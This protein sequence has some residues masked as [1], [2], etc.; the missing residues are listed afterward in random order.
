MQTQAQSLLP[1][2]ADDADEPGGS[3]PAELLR[4]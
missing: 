2:A 4:L 1:F 3:V